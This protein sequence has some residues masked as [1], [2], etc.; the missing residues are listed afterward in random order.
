MR[1]LTKLLIG[2]L[3]ITCCALGFGFYEGY[4]V[5][6]TASSPHNLQ[7]SQDDLNLVVAD[8]QF[9]ALVQQY[10]LSLGNPELL[11]DTKV[12][13][14]E[15]VTFKLTGSDQDGPIVY[16]CTVRSMDNQPKEVAGCYYAQ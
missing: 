6:G 8:P 2:F 14:S 12:G 16:V 13:A 3:I 5:H 11:D 9:K 15:I 7:P 1:S 10:H 4:T